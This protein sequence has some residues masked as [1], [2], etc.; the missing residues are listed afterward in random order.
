MFAL[1]GCLPDKDGHPSGALGGSLARW[2]DTLGMHEYEK[3]GCYETTRH[4]S[5]RRG[6]MLRL[7]RR[8]SRVVTKSGQ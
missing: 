6:Q 7:P 8:L 4:T 2:F 3:S 1:E 5:G